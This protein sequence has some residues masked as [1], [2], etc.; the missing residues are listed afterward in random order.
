M[1]THGSQPNALRQQVSAEFRAA[2]Q[3][4][5][6]PEIEPYLSRVEPDQRAGLLRDLLTIEVAGRRERGESPTSSE[7]RARFEL[8]TGALEHLF[9]EET[10]F[11][12]EAPESAPDQSQEQVELR[13]ES[14]AVGDVPAT[15]MQPAPGDITDRTLDA[16]QQQ[17]HDGTWADA[18]PRDD[19]PRL[20]QIPNFEDL[21]L[22]GIGGMGMVVRAR[23]TSLD[24][25]VAI[26]LPRAEAFS[27]QERE[28]FERE[29]RS[30]ARLRHPNICPIYEVSQFDGRPYIVMGFIHGVDLR[31]W[32]K[33]EQPS[34]EEIA[35]MV[36]LLARAVGYAHDH[37][38][39]HRDLKPSNVLV[40]SETGAPILMDFGLAKE[41]GEDDSHLT[42]SGQIMGTPAYMAP[43]QADGRHDRIAPA[44]DVYSLGAIL[45]ELICGRTPF[46]GSVGEVLHLVQTEE[47][48]V[49]RSLAPRTPR[50]L[51]TIC[52]RA[53]AKDPDKRYSSA[54]RL[55]E[56]LARF[57]EGEPIL[58][59]RQSLAARAWKRVRRSPGFA[60]AALVAVVAAVAVVYSLGGASAARQVT[61]LTQ[62]LTQHLDRKSWTAAG[63]AESEQLIAQ[64]EQL[65]PEHAADQREKLPA[66]VARHIQV[67]MIGAPALD[68]EGI[69][70]IE[71][72]LDLLAKR[73]PDTAAQLHQK[74]QGRMQGW[75]PLFEL[76]GPYDNLK[77]VFGD[78]QVRVEDGR[79]LGVAERSL[80]EISSRGNLQLE[81]TFSPDWAKGKE[82]ALWLHTWNTEQPRG[83][84][85]VLRVPTPD[86]AELIASRRTDY[87]GNASL[88][89]GEEAE[90]ELD[91]KTMEEV[92]ARHGALEMAIYRDGQ[93]L[94]RKR[95]HVPKD[96]IS[97][98]V[99]REGEHLRFQINQQLRVEFSDLLAVSKAHQGVF[100]VEIPAEVKWVRL[101]AYRQSLPEVQSPLER[102]DTL[103]ADSR[104][105]E[106][107]GEYRTQ[108]LSSVD[109]TFG[110][111]ARYKQSL[112]LGRLG[113]KE[114]AD[115]LL[116]QLAAEEGDRWPLLAAVQLWVDR[117]ERKQGDEAF[118]IFETISTR[119]QPEQ[120][121]ML[122][123]ATVQ[124]WVCHRYKS[125]AIG[126]R[127]LTYEP[128]RVK[129][130]EQTLRVEEFLDVHDGSTNLTRFALFRSHFYG[131]QYDQAI[132]M[133]D[134][135]L[136]HNEWPNERNRWFWHVIVEERAW[137]QRMQGQSEQALVDL[138]RRLF[139]ERGEI[140]PQKLMLLVE[141]ARI[142]VALEKWEQA[143][144]DLD[145]FFDLVRPEMFDYYRHFS[146]ASLIQGFLLER[147]DQEEAAL[148]A[149]RRAA[150]GGESGISFSSITGNVPTIQAAILGM[151]TDQLTIR[152]VEAAAGKILGVS[153]GTNVPVMRTMLGVFSPEITDDRLT[154]ML[155]SVWDDPR[156]RGV[157]RSA[158]YR[159]IPLTEQ[160]RRTSVAVVSHGAEHIGYPGQLNDD[161]R[162]LIRLGAD[163]GY[164]AYTSGRFSKTNAVQLAFTWNGNLS[165]LGWGGLEPD[166]KPPLKGRLA[167]FLGLRLLNLRQRD[168]ALKLLR[169][170]RAAADKDPLLERLVDAKLKEF[171]EQMGP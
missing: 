128:Q 164:V 109:T 4:G 102:G 116:V 101:A 13:G 148:A 149:W 59:R 98:T 71:A 41:L 25:L 65:D 77:S 5:S 169:V 66:R 63:L 57:C 145:Q 127:L 99:R 171:E 162:E 161:Q 36:E 108:S 67:D 140:H 29:A 165:F 113:R 120:V 83:Y 9:S 156:R 53:M 78:D 155:N 136:R 34:P 80:T 154:E 123:P 132:A 15:I 129:R 112:C 27:S 43:E 69:E 46:V 133:A 124:L 81:A 138:D 38:V 61:D 84:R 70:D 137:V 32:R 85:F 105:Q 60:T 54:I 106:A 49:P 35:G 47:P 86:A 93:L 48:P 134:E 150:P 42:Y 58:A 89:P 121:A 40:D 117:L 152:E 75:D 111:E 6:R 20:P 131:Q 50:D 122:V 2:W 39:L 52:L 23:Q 141:R 14:A 37:G 62:Q 17:A 7:Y 74:L 166:L 110:R 135:L 90:D 167:Y 139:N 160:V 33:S 76:T 31:S 11:D 16:P 96:W 147:L 30:A 68:A 168:S 55:A 88:D 130:I 64:L 1:S 153:S 26:K 45:Y 97:I 158:A 95:V 170:A 115:Q 118:E 44:T 18:P 91:A 19:S 107:L 146:S 92:Y 159:D 144:Q 104:F 21:H 56:D 126:V 24:R 125:A 73:D 12:P 8:L 142:H 143:Q 82:I 94:R 10:L 79:L 87:E 51:E 119:Y 28:R 72:A 3:S 157:A 22:I 114:E 163:A 100:G 103:F 151:L